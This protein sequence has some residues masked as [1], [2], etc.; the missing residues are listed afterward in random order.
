VRWNILF[1]SP[2]AALLALL[3]IFGLPR[4]EFQAEVVCMIA[5]VGA[6]F[7]GGWLAETYSDRAPTRQ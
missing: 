3:C 1:A 7:V 6:F 4:G 2:F 5:A